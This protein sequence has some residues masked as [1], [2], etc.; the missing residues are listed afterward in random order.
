MFL[1]I[2]NN[3]HS[4]VITGLRSSHTQFAVDHLGESLLAQLCSLLASPTKG[5]TLQRAAAIHRMGP[6]FSLRF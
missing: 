4:L 1:L 2:L 3:C 5:G 6:A